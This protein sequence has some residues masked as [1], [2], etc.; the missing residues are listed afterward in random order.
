MAKIAYKLFRQ[1]KT[2][3]ITSLYC[4][5]TRR[6]SYNLWMDAESFPT[7][8]FKERPYWHCTEQPDAPHL[9]MKLKTGEI[10]IWKVVLIED[11]IEV[12]R[13]NNQGGLWFLAKRIK[14]L[15]D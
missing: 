1:L 7:K 11:Y 14:I 10:R 2:G 15:D 12:K 3:E 9:Y 6:L 4:N 13:P 8:G 5:K